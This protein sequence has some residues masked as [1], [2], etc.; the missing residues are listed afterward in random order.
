VKL[1]ATAEEKAAR[2][3]VCRECDRRQEIRVPLAKVVLSKCRAMSCG[4]VLEGKV[5]LRA[6]QCPL[7]KW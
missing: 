6:N 7:N 5:V 1:L 2:L 4:C 3:A